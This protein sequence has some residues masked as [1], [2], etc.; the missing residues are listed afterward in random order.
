MDEKG[1]IFTIDAVLALIPILIVLMAV[2]NIQ[3]PNNSIPSSSHIIDAQDMLNLLGEY[4]DGGEPILQRLVD[5]LEINHN[6]QIGINKA[7]EIVKPLLNKF[8]NGRSYIFKEK[9]V[10]NSTISSQGD[11]LKCP[12]VTIATRNWGNY[13]FE[14]QVGSN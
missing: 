9:S 3:H 6:N 1:A 14:L 4:Q 5:E 2:G 12:Q 8:L 11:I 13:T 10:V 7:S